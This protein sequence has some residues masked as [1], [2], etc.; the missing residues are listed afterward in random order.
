M[1]FQYMLTSFLI[2]LGSI[3]MGLSIFKTAR[4]LT[5]LKDGR[6]ARSWRLLIFLMIFFLIGYLIVIGLIAA[7]MTHLLVGLT[8]V[9]FL[10]GALFVYLVVQ[11]GQLTI[12]DLLQTTVSK[13]I[14]EIT[15]EQ[16]KEA[17]DQ[18]LDASRTKSEFLANMSH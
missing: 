5:L 4:I 18:A 7:G 14:L 8:G 2:G 16:L 15:S 1:T 13:E 6:Y 10:F 9:I 12:E 17:R 11:T 3:M